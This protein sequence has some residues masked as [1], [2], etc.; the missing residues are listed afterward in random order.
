M[1]LVPVT[2]VAVTFVEKT[3][4]VVIAFEAYKLPV[5]LIPVTPVAGVTTTFEATTLP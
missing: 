2:F 5:T 1:T 4:V 3:L